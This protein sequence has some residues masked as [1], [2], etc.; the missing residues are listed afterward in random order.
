MKTFLRA[1]VALAA[2]PTFSV[3]IAQNPPN[4]PDPA[5]DPAPMRVALTG[6]A[7]LDSAR[8][9]QR[10]FELFRRDNLP[11][12]DVSGT[13]GPESADEALTVGRFRYWYDTTMPP[14]PPEPTEI[15]AERAKL[16]ALLDSAATK[17]PS[18]DWVVGQRVRYLE[19]SGRYDEEVAAAVA[20]RGAPWWCA[21]LTGFAYHNTRQYL[22]ADSAFQ[23][24]LSLMA[25]RMRCDWTDV[26]IVLD[27][28]TRRTY[29]RLPCGSA[30]REQ[31]ESRLWWLSKPLY[32][33]EGLDTRT[34]FYARMTMT[35]LLKDAITVYFFGFDPDEREL[36]LRYGW[37]RAWSQS[38]RRGRESESV[39][40]HEPSPSYQFLPP[41]ALASSPSSSDSVDW[42]IGIKPVYA[43]YAPAYA[44]RIRALPHQSALFRRG[45]SA[46]VVV[47]WDATALNFGGTGAPQM[48]VALARADSLKPWVTRVTNASL[49][50]STI[51]MGPWG[52]LVMSAEF[53]R[54]DADTAARARYGLRPPWSIG[55]R[56][57]LS[58]MLFFA[59]YDGLPE[60]VEEA[61]K[62]ATTSIKLR[63]NQ[64]L[65]VFFE[66]YGTKPEGEK[67]KY[68]LTVAREDAEEGFMRRRIQAITPSRQATPLSIT[69]EDISLP[70]AKVT[71]RAF[72]L[73]VTQLRKGAY[74]VQLEVDVAGQYLVISERSLEIVEK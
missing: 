29:R 72:Y 34:E 68:T 54:A 32:A 52:Q 66:T 27:D 39:V 46:L 15:V 43:R 20:C 13:N 49:R 26:G 24:G 48:A 6:V 38:G 19:E 14:A 53:T 37:P 12:Y 11:Q 59:P 36:L 56:V 22:R 67:L 3:A 74:I 16:I 7:L 51:A 40:G 1:F 64:K 18:D 10:E 63:N 21:V 73:D 9:A 58:E 25:P 2:A 44:R 71:A 62:H 17:Y 47:A 41:A 60:T 42:E 31:Y 69:H 50:G 33:R 35:H 61:A 55:A 5:F 57:S 28:Y 8:R 70:N 30:E 23:A 45:D 65:G 4:L